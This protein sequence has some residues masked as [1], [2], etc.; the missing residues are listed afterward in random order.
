MYELSIEVKVHFNLDNVIGA[1]QSP[2]I[3]ITITVLLSAF[4]A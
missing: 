1:L 2:R 3:A 4:A